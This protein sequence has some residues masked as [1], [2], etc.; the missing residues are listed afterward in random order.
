MRNI[1]ICGLPGYKI[2]LTFYHKRQDF[3]TNVIEYKIRVLSCSTKC[4]WKNFSS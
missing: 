4:V 1:V 3:R 2:F